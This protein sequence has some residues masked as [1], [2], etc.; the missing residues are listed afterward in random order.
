MCKAGAIINNKSISLLPNSDF[1]SFSAL[2]LNSKCVTRI[3][4]LLLLIMALACAKLDLLAMTPQ[5]LF[6]HPLL[7][8]PDTR[9]SWLVWDKRMPTSV[10]KLNP[11][12]VSSH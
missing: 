5:G 7:D 1:H 12:E 3:L 11:R 10:M 2:K 6:S 9:V 8:V 4:L